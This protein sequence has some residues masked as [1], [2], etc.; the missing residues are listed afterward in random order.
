MGSA[1]QNLLAKAFNRVQGLPHVCLLLP[2]RRL[3]RHTR[4]HCLWF[5]EPFPRCLGFLPTTRCRRIRALEASMA[6]VSLA[7]MLDSHDVDCL[8][9]R[10]PT[11]ARSFVRMSAT[12]QSVCY[13]SRRVYNAVRQAHVIL[14]L[15]DD[16]QGVQPC[17][18]REFTV[19]LPIL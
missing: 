17:H 16:G 3:G 10:Y 11:Q 18:E 7:A 4:P 13:P 9:A 5:P 19:A 2:T 14:Q 12:R 6:I 8:S 15:E 1:P